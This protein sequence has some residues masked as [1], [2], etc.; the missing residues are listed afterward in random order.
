MGSGMVPSAAAAGAFSAA[1]IADLQQHK[2]S[3]SI[4]PERP[5]HSKSWWSDISTKPSRSLCLA[6]QALQSVEERPHP[7]KRPVSSR[8]LVQT[9]RSQIPDMERWQFWRLRNAGY[10]AMKSTKPHDDATAHTASAGLP[11][12]LSR[13]VRVL[14]ASKL[15]VIVRP[16]GSTLALD[17]YRSAALQSSF[18]TG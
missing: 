17:R 18:L 14:N 9:Q 5:F 6:C 1:L 15:N 2:R 13:P 3:G 16:P 7:S 4:F 11:R 10:C 8:R 12:H